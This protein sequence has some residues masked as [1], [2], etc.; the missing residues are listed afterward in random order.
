MSGIANLFRLAV[1]TYICV[2]SQKA[3][4]VISERINLEIECKYGER[5]EYKWKWRKSIFVYLF[6]RQSGVVFTLCDI[7]VLASPAQKRNDK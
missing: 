7:F 1:V 6:T 2:E 3:K 4:I 5:R